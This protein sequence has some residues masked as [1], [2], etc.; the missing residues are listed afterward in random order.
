MER[1]IGCVK[2][3]GTII[4]CGSCKEEATGKIVA[5]DLCRLWFHIKCQD[6][7]NEEF[8]ALKK[9]KK[10]KWFC[11]RCTIV[12]NGIMSCIEKLMVRQDRM[13]IEINEVKSKIGEEIGRV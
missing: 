3:G 6:I 11:D 10:L 13:E 1:E 2:D 4:K 7:A 12:S 5:C 8:S 9:F